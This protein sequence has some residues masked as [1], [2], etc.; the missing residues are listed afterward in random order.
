M[1]LLFAPLAALA[2][3]TIAALVARLLQRRQAGLIGTVRRPIAEAHADILYFTG[4]NCTICEVAQRPALTRL[5]AAMP[6]VVIR[7]IDIAVEPDLARGYRVMTLPTTIVM[8]S[9]GAVAAINTGFASDARLRAQV[10]Q[11]RSHAQVPVPA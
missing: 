8:G 10:E 6:G 11:T 7:E 2:L 5:V 3:L 1:S 9:G 4:E